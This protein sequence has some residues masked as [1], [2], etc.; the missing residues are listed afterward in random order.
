LV[1]DQNVQAISGLGLVQYQRWSCWGASQRQAFIESCLPFRR[2][3]VDI[4]D[5]GSASAVNFN[6]DKQ[7]EGDDLTR[8]LTSTDR[9]ERALN[10]LLTDQ[11][12]GDNP[13]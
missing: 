5:T 8:R 11:R 2:G 6:C 7:G 1:Q 4:C 12:R 13:H 9:I 10:A 3:K